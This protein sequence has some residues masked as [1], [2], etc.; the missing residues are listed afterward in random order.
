MHFKIKPDHISNSIREIYPLFEL[1]TNISQLYIRLGLFR[2][3][4]SVTNAYHINNYSF[5]QVSVETFSAGH[6]DET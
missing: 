2:A 1:L 5:S 6:K 4:K 3:F